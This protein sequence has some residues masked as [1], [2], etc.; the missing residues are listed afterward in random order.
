MTPDLLR[1]MLSAGGSVVV[2]VLI[3]GYLILRRSPNNGDTNGMKTDILQRIDDL[4]RDGDNRGKDI[5]ESIESLT[6]SVKSI[7]GRFDRHLE[8]HASHPINKV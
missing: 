1:E 6:G 7:E 5:K 8:F 3:L 4:E 2:L